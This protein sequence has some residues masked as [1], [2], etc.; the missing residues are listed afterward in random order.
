[1]RPQ[2]SNEKWIDS[3]NGQAQVRGVTPTQKQFS[4]NRGA[5]QKQIPIRYSFFNLNA[6]PNPYCSAVIVPKLRKL[7]EK[8]VIRPSTLQ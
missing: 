2:L 7:V 8:G 1:M 6:N 4:L 3:G 5:S